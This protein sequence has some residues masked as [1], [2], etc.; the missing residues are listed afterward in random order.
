MKVSFS[1]AFSK[2]FT[3]SI[4]NGAE[5]DAKYFFK[6]SFNSEILLRASSTSESS[7]LFFSA[8]I[9]EVVQTGFIASFEPMS[10]KFSKL[11]PIEGMKKFF[12][13]KQY[14]ELVKSVL[15]MIIVVALIYSVVKDALPI[16]AI[17][18]KMNLWQLMAYTGDL[19]M[20]VVIRVGIFYIIIALL[21]YLY[22]RYEWIKGLM[23]SKKEIKDEYKRLE[24]DPL[25]KQRQRDAQRQMAMGRQMGAVPDADVVV[26]NPIHFALAIS[27]DAT[28]KKAP[29]VLAKGKRLVAQQI[30]SIAQDYQIPVIENPLLARS[31]YK[32]TEV[33]EEIPEAYYKVVAQILAFVYNLRKNRAKYR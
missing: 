6:Y 13:L 33:D 28:R 22:Q 21:D 15:K 32:E 26:T 24:G 12:T 7:F 19:V 31:L 27:Y 2:S 17:S 1:T 5:S 14:V 20:K 25:I 16:V 9:V 3:C 18:Q 10:P 30:K 29:I 11:N 4:I 8:I 23:M